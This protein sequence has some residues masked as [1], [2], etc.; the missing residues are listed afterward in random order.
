M[1][2][3]I[4]YI[5][6]GAANLGSFEHH[7]DLDQVAWADFDRNA[8]IITGV[9]W[10]LVFHCCAMI[11]TTCALIDRWRGPYDKIRTGK[12]SVL[13]ALVLSVCWPAV[14]AYMMLS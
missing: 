13:A 6:G 9:T 11:W 2:S 5:K 7:P 12:S 1:G 4:S 14:L 10:A 3:L 8:M